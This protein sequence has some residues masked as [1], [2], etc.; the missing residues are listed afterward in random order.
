MKH[1]VRGTVSLALTSPTGDED[2]DAPRLA[3]SQ[4]FVTLGSEIE[5][6]DG[7][8]AVIGTVVEGQEEGGTLDKINAAFVDEKMR[9]LQDIRI[10][11]AE[12]LGEC[13]SSQRTRGGCMRLRPE[14]KACYTT[15]ADALRLQMIP[16]PILKGSSY[17]LAR[18][19]PRLRS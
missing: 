18:P 19:R 9:P 12:V 5:Y 1:S 7:K 3:G 11:H 2:E 8:H 16:F 13:A 6:L 4:F 15:H 14:S 17:P 10:R